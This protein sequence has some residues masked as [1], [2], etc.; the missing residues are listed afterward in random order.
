MSIIHADVK[1]Q[2]EITHARF[3]ITKM[4]S[5]ENVEECLLVTFCDYGQTILLINLLLASF[6]TV[7]FVK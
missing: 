1:M 6:Q 2:G 7:T 5:V 3:K 4:D